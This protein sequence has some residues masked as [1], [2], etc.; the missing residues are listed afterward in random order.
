[1]VVMEVQMPFERAKESLLKRREISPQ[2]KAVIVTM[3]EEP[4]YV[5]ELMR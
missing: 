3:F 1:V 4:R 2:P 5:R